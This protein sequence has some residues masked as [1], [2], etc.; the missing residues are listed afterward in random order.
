MNTVL[1]VPLATGNRALTIGLFLAV[2]AVTLYITFWASRQSKTAADA[3]ISKRVPTR[4]A[5]TTRGYC[6]RKNGT[7]P[8]NTKG[9]SVTISLSAL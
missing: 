4:T 9:K 6:V 7:V 8:A 1:L 5:T 3:K 2:V